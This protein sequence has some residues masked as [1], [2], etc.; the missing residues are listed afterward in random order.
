M[1]HLLVGFTAQPAECSRTSRPGRCA[2]QTT[3]VVRIWNA[4]GVSQEILAQLVG[5][6][7]QRVNQVLKLWEED[8]L[9]EQSYGR[10]L[11]VDSVR[12]KRLAED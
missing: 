9:V 2:V 5:V 11:L 3:R 12:L 6:T 1:A 4:T 10:I 8:G 7:R